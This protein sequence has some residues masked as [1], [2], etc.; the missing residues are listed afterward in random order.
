MMQ[1]ASGR[2]VKT[3][4]I[5]FDEQEFN[6]ARYAAAVAEHLGTDHTDLLLTGDDAQALVPRLPEIFDEPLADPSQ[7]PT[8]LVSQL[9]RQQV[10][11][12]LC[13]DGGD[14]LFGGYNR[15]VYGKRVLPRVTRVPG[16]VRRSIGAGLESLPSSMWDGMQRMTAVVAPG[17][18]ATRFGER[19]QKLANVMT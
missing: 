14:E 15:Y 16:V 2:P 4:T 12:A 3:Y 7:L 11:V 9:A 17:L 13:G 6:E 18:P 5:G 10:T 1:E 19:V 8:L